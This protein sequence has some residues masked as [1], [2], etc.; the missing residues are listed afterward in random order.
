[1]ENIFKSGNDESQIPFED[2]LKS[3]NLLKEMFKY[4][5]DLFGKLY[6][7]TTNYYKFNTMMLGK[8]LDNYNQY[9]Q[10]KKYKEGTFPANGHDIYNHVARYGMSNSQIQAIM[11]LDERL[12]FDKLK[13]AVR[14]SVD[15]EPILKCR[16]VEDASPYWKQLENIGVIDFCCMEET[17]H[18]DQTIENFIKSPLD[19]DNDSMVKVKLIRSK[20]YDVLALKIDHACA[21]GAGAQEYIKL[22]A[23]IYSNINQENDTFTP[24]PRIAGRKDQDRLFAEL[25]ITNPDSLFIPGSDISI[26]MWSFPWEKG[27]SNTVCVS[28]CRLPYEH[29]DSMIKYTKSKGVTLNDFILTAYYRAMLEMGQPVYGFP[30]EIPTTVDL[31]RYLPGHKTQAIRNFSGSEKT[32]LSMSIN[33]PFAKTLQRVADMMKEIKKRYPGLQS[34]IGLERIEKLNFRDTLGYYQASQEARKITS[35]CPL[36]YGDKCVPTLSN[37]GYLSRSL[38]KFGSSTVIDAYIVPPV[39]RAPGVL[40]MANTYNSVLTLAIGYYKYTVERE[41]IEKL[42]NKIKDELIEGCKGVERSHVLQY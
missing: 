4:N 27:G 42:L 10:N 41:N 29:L 5:V 31:R 20:Q 32:N 6:Q 37:L 14:L 13:R 11:R 36:Y 8:S 16:F 19:I 9:Y 3:G 18:I 34:A 23:D 15:A 2:I 25:G 30:L 35:S 22:L 17:D 12:D 33:E 24:E 1:M 28:I 39:V 26:P 40:L 7:N 38:I 21:D